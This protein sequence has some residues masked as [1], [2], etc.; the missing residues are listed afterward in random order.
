[1]KNILPILL[2]VF[3]LTAAL[4]SCGRKNTETDTGLVPN[5][6]TNVTDQT[7][8]TTDTT[9][10]TENTELSDAASVLNAVWATYAD[11]EKFAAAG[12]DYNHP[13]DGAP[14][15]FDITDTASLESM[16]VLPEASVSFIDD[17]AS[18]MH[19]MNANTFTC[20]AFH[21]TEDEN[22]ATITETLRDALQSRHWMCGFP[23]KFVIFTYNNYVVSLFG[24]EEL[25][26]N[27]RDKFVNIYPD[28]SIS[29]EEAIE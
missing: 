23:D 15:A 2:T 26:N 5:D 28:A 25:V 20:G 27:F 29:Y 13:V 19:M 7:D 1:M 14:G 8:D 10:D 4:V 18:L 9:S 17:A 11:D 6:T 24:N 16:L 21:V 22:V 3:L 12:G